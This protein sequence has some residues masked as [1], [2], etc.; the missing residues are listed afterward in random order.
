VQR[1]LL[2]LADGADVAERRALD[3]AVDGVGRGGLVAARALDWVERRGI[4]AAVDGLARG[5]GRGGDDLRGLQTGRL[6]EYLRNAVLG[7]AAVAFLVAL[8]ALT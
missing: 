7:G 3:A 4:D 8:S 6:F 2:A 1:P 5:V